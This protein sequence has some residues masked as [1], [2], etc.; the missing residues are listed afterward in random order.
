MV[1]ESTEVIRAVDAKPRRSSRHRRRARVAID[2]RSIVGKRYAELAA[3]FHERLNA[4]QD[5]V[6]LVAIEKAA[7]FS[8]L[9]EHAAARALRADPAVS[10]DDVVRLARWADVCVRRLH[11]DRHNTKQQATL[12]DYLRS[13]SE[14]TS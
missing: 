14:S 3:N 1:A 9:A 8:A 10:L 7:R 5:P 2:K 11:L 12:A 13:R 6:L 4:D